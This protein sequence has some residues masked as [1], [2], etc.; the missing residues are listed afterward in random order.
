MEIKRKSNVEGLRAIGTTLVVLSHFMVLFY[1]ASYWDN[2]VC[3]TKQKIESEQ[4]RCA[5]ACQGCDAVFLFLNKKAVETK[6]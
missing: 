1:P 4:N 3:H 5:M 6:S 2:A